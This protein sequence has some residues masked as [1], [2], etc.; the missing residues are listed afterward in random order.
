MRL[1]RLI[2]DSLYLK[3]KFYKKMGYK[4]NLKD[5][6]TFNEKLQWLK[7]H[8]RKEIYST[9]VDKY[10]VKAYVASL[11]GDEYII[12]TLGVW[13]Q[14]DD[15]D[16][17]KLPDQFVLK[18]THDSGGL[19]ICPDKQKLDKDEAKQKIETSLKENFYWMAREWPYKNV[20]PRIIAEQ[21][22]AENLIDYKYFC[23]NGVPRLTLVCSERFTESG[24]KEDFFDEAWSHLNVARPQHPNSVH[25]IPKPVHFET[26]KKLAKVIASNTTFSRI[27]FY[28]VKDKVY[29]GEIT[30]YPGSGFDGFNPPDWDEKL[31]TWIELPNRGVSSRM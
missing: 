16:F 10:E 15:I 26:M 18:C 20:K 19:V 7:L 4:L 22:M 8:D 14:F 1:L 28:E 12:P 27:D 6:K 29:F 9:M 23:F 21:Y 25:S 13:N 3:I 30:F 17:D 2:P 11:I 24:L 31:G 5:P